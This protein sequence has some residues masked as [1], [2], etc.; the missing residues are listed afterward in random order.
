MFSGLNNENLGACVMINE[1][2]EI[3]MGAAS[4]RILGIEDDNSDL[5]N[6][7]EF[8]NRIEN[9]LSGLAFSSK[10]VGYDE[11]VR[12]YYNYDD[13]YES[14]I[15][16]SGNFYPY[17]RGAVC[18]HKSNTFFFDVANIKFM[19]EKNIIPL[20]LINCD[21]DFQQSIKIPRSNG[22]VN[23]GRSVIN[24]ALKI[25]KTKGGVYAYVRFFDNETNFDMEKHTKINELFD[26]N[27][28]DKFKIKIPQLNI[29]DYNFDDGKYEYLSSSLID[30]IIEYYNSKVNEFMDSFVE[31]ITEYDVCKNE[32][33]N[34]FIFNKKL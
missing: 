11:F 30:E 32:D 8:E 25:S 10:A 34:E 5:S 31:N 14:F 18:L 21:L 29:Q 16:G 2:N 12:K 13:V 22:S 15:M 33:D 9:V 17:P 1:K 24:S 3:T 7:E 4:K 19:I 23:E 6:F 28:I 27:N 20:D 26:C